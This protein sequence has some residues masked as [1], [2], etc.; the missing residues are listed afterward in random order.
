MGK[1]LEGR[2]S[3]GNSFE[4]E[5]KEI[6]NKRPRMKEKTSIYSGTLRIG[7]NH[8]TIRMPATSLDLWLKVWATLFMVPGLLLFVGEH[9]LRIE[10]LSF[11][12]LF[13][14]VPWY[15]HEKACVTLNAVWQKVGTVWL[16]VLTPLKASRNSSYFWVELSKSLQI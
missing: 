9:V 8:L 13:L 6:E 4:D 16:D 10:E 12:K 1:N 11:R 14:P 5:G 2:K 15:F 7:L 3:L